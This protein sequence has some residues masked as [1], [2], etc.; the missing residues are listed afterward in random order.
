MQPAS[1]VFVSV[2]QLSRRLRRSPVLLSLSLSL[3]M[4]RAALGVF[5][6]VRGATLHLFPLSEIPVQEELVEEGR[7]GSLHSARLS[8]RLSIRLF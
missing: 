1:P 5:Y 2:F 6:V 3:S 7:P 4:K 8:A